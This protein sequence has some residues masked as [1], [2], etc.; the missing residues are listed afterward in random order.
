VDGNTLVAPLPGGGSSGDGPGTGATGGGVFHWL[1]KKLGPSTAD[2]IP[3][4]LLVL[5]G[6]AFAVT[7]LGG[8]EKPPSAT[9]E[10]SSKDSTKTDA[11]KAPDDSS[12]SSSSS[13]GTASKEA[14]IRD[15]YAKAP[16]GS[17]EAW[18]ML[19]P[20]MQSMGRDRYLGFWRTIKSVDVRDVQ[21]DSGGD[22][23]EVTLVYRTTDGKTSTERKREKL[24][25]TDNGSYQIESDVPAT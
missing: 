15:Y 24:S 23:V 19:A 25:A 5:G 9:G 6:L 22:T 17:D 3:I 7:H 1:A 11:Q 16:G 12:S 18:A 10:K 21:A 13:K 4:P 2:S 14:F 20:A 8:G